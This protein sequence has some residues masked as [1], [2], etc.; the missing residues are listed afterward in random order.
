MTA[1]RQEAPPLSSRRPCA[2]QPRRGVWQEGTF[3]G[4]PAPL[5]QLLGAHPATLSSARALVQLR[6]ETH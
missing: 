5:D 1:P 2:Q 6:F 4:P 3:L